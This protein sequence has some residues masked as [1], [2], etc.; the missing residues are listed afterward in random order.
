MITHAEL[1]AIL[2]QGILVSSGMLIYSGDCCASDQYATQIF[3]HL[4]T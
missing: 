4:A 2:F 3:L 1:T